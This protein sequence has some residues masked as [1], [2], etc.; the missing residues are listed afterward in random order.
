MMSERE[1]EEPWLS[2]SECIAQADHAGVNALLEQLDGGEIARALTRLDEEEQHRLLMMLHPEEAADLIEELVDAQGADILEDLPVMDAAAIVAEMES[3][4]RA[5]LLG[6]MDIEDA[7]KILQRMAPADAADARRLLQY[8]ENTAGGVMVTEYLAYPQT[9]E[10]REV[11]ADMRENA[12]EYSDYGVQYAYVESEEKRLVGV[13]RLRDLLLAPSEK[14]INT[15]MIANPIYVLVNT[16]LNDLDHFFERYT[17]WGVPVTDEDGHMLGV[18]RRADMEEAVGEEHERALLRFGGI[19]GG[20]ELRSMPLLERSSRRLVWLGLN[21]VL[22]FLAASVI[23]FFEDTISYLFAIV[24]FMPIICNM[25]GCS[26]NQAV[27]V[28][29]RELTLGLIEPADF[30]RVWMKELAVGFVNGLVI[31]SFIA[32]AA[33]LINLFFWHQS[34]WLAVIIGSAFL[35][36]TMIAVSLGGVIP[37]TLRLVHADP[38]LGAPPVLTTL[39]DMCGLLLV[40]G[41]AT[42]AILFGLI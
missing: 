39:T 4:E 36:N 6:E 26:G 18:V 33:A 34:P 23:L 41:M 40:L 9:A 20:E 16:Q 13:L 2:L 1:I 21:V 22:S 37:L 25:S 24:F 31:G 14:P 35:L 32:A 12:E 5:D 38:A 10:V 30:V 11:L 15:I 3:D 27:A 42:L 17:F 19:I 28:S 8:D 29:I 7:E